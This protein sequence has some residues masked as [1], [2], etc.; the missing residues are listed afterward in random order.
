M[1]PP[2][3]SAS[4]KALTPTQI[5]AAFQQAAAL[6]GR[7]DLAQAQALYAEIVRRQ[8]KHFD[9]LHGLGV[10]AYQTRDFRRAAELIT[11]AIKI[12]PD[13]ATFHSNYGL[14]LLDMGDL[15]GALAAFDRAIVLGPN[16]ASAFSNK[17]NALHMLGRYPEALA[18]CERAVALVPRDAGAHF[19]RA[20]TLHVLGRLPEAL[21]S[22][23]QCVALAPDYADAHV[24]RGNVLQ[25][26]DRLEE[27]IAAFDR[28]IAVDHTMAAA[29]AN[30][31]MVRKS[32]GRL[33]D[34]VSDFDQAL[35]ID[36]KLVA[37]YSARG[38]IHKQCGD[39][40]RALADFTRAVE[41]DPGNFEA[42]KNFFW[43][44]LWRSADPS[45]V[46]R[47]SAELAHIKADLDIATLRS[48]K[49]IPAFRLL[50][51]LE[52]A[53]YLARDHSDLDGLA[54]ARTTLN[55]I[56]ARASSADGGMNEAA[57]S[58]SEIEV[59]GRFRRN[60]LRYA[61]TL[62]QVAVNPTNNWSAIEDRYLA[63]KPEIVVIDNFL[64]PEALDQLRRFCLVSNVWRTDYGNEYLGA[65]P[66]D[67]FISPLHLQIAAELRRVLPRIVGDHTLEQMWAFKYTSRSGK[68]IGI[69]ADFA[70]V[71]LNFW[72]TPDD[73]NLD[74]ASGGMEIYDIPAPREWDFRDYN[75]AS[76]KIYAF[77]D[78][79]NAVRRS[80][81]YKSNRAVMFNSNLFHKTADIRF[82]EGYENRRMNVTYLFGVGLGFP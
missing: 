27:S 45:V 65:F 1:S 15:A 7:G 9:A 12:F 53:D 11:Q 37:V 55:A 34:A 81:P 31:G 21:A 10:I 80:I 6:H 33:D 2:S 29:Y 42:R 82:K 20:Q 73:A 47:L 69:H 17:G 75:G 67:G 56:Y 35:A 60:V 44:H 48:N 51:D 13:S 3:S 18:N 28:A 52:Q 26:M 72:I 8:P 79:N 68:G 46:D 4:D 50:H 38:A 54:D 19:N 78:A 39:L 63:V 58:D 36:D 64:T 23:D 49:R 16:F 59:V 61:P 74:P 24:N 25:E 76:D 5:G 57:V 77:L 40:D 41:L 30:R 14:A 32:L 70:R 66:E 43:I 71:N 62:P 22:Y